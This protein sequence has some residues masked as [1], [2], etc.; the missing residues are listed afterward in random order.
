LQ[1]VAEVVMEE[2]G[3]DASGLAV[4]QAHAQAKHTA[5]VRRGDNRDLPARPF[6]V[7]VRRVEQRDPE[8]VAR[9]EVDPASEQVE[10]DQE[11]PFCDLPLLFVCARTCLTYIARRTKHGTAPRA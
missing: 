4:S 6:L 10:D 8:L 9:L 2:L 3:V 7:L 5:P 1:L 11:R